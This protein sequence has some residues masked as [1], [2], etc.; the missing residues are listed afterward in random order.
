MSSG[1]NCHNQLNFENMLSP[2]VNHLFRTDPIATLQALSQQKDS[3]KTLTYVAA[4]YYRAGQLLRAQHSPVDAGFAEFHSLET[5]T[6]KGQCPNFE[7]AVMSSRSPP[8]LKLLVFRTDEIVWPPFSKESELSVN[9]IPFWRAPSCSVPATLSTLQI[10]G[11]D[12][13]FTASMKRVIISVAKK[14]QQAGVEL[15][16]QVETRS[17]YFPP[18]LY[19]EPLPKTTTVFAGEWKHAARRTSTLMNRLTS[20]NEDSS[21][22][23]WTSEEE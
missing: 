4:Q 12:Q 8:G 1:E 9:E 13:D 14:M 3:L 16:V 15:E 7:R 11:R 6:L 18:Y 23:E 22:E 20:F 10:I 19:G 2:D 5:V 17:S 21:D